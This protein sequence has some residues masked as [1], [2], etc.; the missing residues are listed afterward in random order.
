MSCYG[1]KYGRAAIPGWLSIPSQHS[2]TIDLLFPA[3]FFVT[4][5]VNR[6]VPFTIKSFIGT[7]W[8]VNNPTDLSNTVDGDFNTKTDNFATDAVFNAETDFG[9]LIFDFGLIKSRKFRIKFEYK[10]SIGA[11]DAEA[12]LFISDDNINYGLP[13]KEFLT[14]STTFVLEDFTSPLPQSFRFLKIACG[15]G[16][17]TVT[18]NI[19]EAG[20]VE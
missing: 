19:Y 15:A 12:V 7:V 14:Q 10:T 16:F 4:E 2:A 5:E 3:P 9:T 17:E 6:N 18:V 20:E 8:K 13:I 11:D 1:W